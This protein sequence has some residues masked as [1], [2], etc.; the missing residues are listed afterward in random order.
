MLIDGVLP[1][2]ALDL[3]SLDFRTIHFLSHCTQTNDLK[4]ILQC[5]M[6][7]AHELVSFGRSGGWRPLLITAQSDHLSSPKNLRQDCDVIG[8]LLAF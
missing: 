6:R 7:I 4:F 1:L 3:A 8:I 5:R 2:Q